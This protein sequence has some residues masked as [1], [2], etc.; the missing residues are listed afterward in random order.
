MKLT[1]VH[2]LLT[3]ECNFECDHCFVWSGPWQPGTLTVAQLDD[4]LRQAKEAET[5]RWIYFEGGEPFLYYPLLRYGVRRAA[6]EGF[7]VGIVSNAYWATGPADARECLRDLAGSVED[8]SMSCDDF[9]GDDEQ[10]R[11]VRCARE[12]AEALGI[13]A[14]TIE[15]APGEPAVGQLPAGESG[16]MYRGRAAVKLAPSAPRRPASGMTECPWED[17]REPGRV[18]VDPLGNVHICQGISVGNLFRTP[19][20]E[21]CASYDPASHPITGPLERGGPAELATRYAVEA[22][23]EYADACHFCYETRRAL[24]ARFPDVLTPDQMYGGSGS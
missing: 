2:L 12:A 24:R 11:H 14:E 4:I 18:H 17:L 10:V 3:Y 1:G 20:R 15:I 22:A 8:L 5:I 16:V 21:I 19:L 23:A 6:E 13:P 7:R 9:H